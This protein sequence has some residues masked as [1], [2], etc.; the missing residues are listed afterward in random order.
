MGQK[1][2][3]GMVGRV[4]QSGAGAGIDPGAGAGTTAVA[5]ARRRWEP[6]LSPGW[7]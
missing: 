2:G 3:G 5:L 7:A 6:L 1:R 4:G